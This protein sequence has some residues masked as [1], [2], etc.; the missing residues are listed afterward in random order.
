[1]A[2]T[3][4]RE[5]SS[6]GAL[7]L[8]VVV[9]YVLPV[10]ISLDSWHKNHSLNL[11]DFFNETYIEKM[12]GAWDFKKKY[13]KYDCFKDDW[14]FYHLHHVCTKGGYDGIL[15]GIEGV[16]N[17]WDHR[18]RKDN[19][20]LS[21]DEW[22]K[23]TELN[24]KVHPLRVHRLHENDSIAEIRHLPGSTLYAN[25]YQQP[26]DSMN[27]AH[28]MMKLGTMFE[29]ATCAIH[30][31]DLGSMNNMFMSGGPAATDLPMKQLYLHQC[32]NP[33]LTDWKWGEN[34]LQIIRDQ[35]HEANIF[36]KTNTQFFN[37]DGYQMHNHTKPYYK[38]TCY[39][40]MYLSQRSGI[41]MQKSYNLMEFRKDSA[42]FMGEPGEALTAP[43][44]AADFRT[45]G[46]EYPN[47]AYCK[48]GAEGKPNPR[49]HVFYRSGIK[50][51]RLFLNL[52]AV[53]KLVQEYT[54]LPVVLFTVNA[55]TSIAEQI[56]MFNQFDVM[57]TPHGSHLANG[58]FTVKPGSKA[59]VEIVP[60]AFDRVFYS[61]YN[62]HLEFG[63]YYMSTGHLTPVQEETNRTM[64]HCFFET[65][66]SFSDSHAKCSTTT[67]R[68]PKRPE[69]KFLT[70][71]VLYQPRMCDTMVNIDKL[72]GHLD[73][74][75]KNNLCKAG[76]PAAPVAAAA[77]PPVASAT[78]ATAATAPVVPAADA[79]PDPNDFHRRLSEFLNDK[80]LPS[81]RVV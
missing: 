72:R 76:A 54:T 25:C 81:L 10:A 50:H 66:E 3:M 8:A 30:N 36:Q 13:F 60:Y 77:A 71:D 4:K 23:K 14:Q 38:L 65:E 41:W 61:N 12:K 33:A 24:T 22:N 28:W 18:R 68:Y 59:V 6:L 21:A 80:H 32:P 67:H 2:L 51:R 19:Y 27:P 79:P 53:V 73:D 57:V 74:L 47:P 35:L 16:V 58:I 63:S 39:E 45:N 29:I 46:E 31:T 48:G 20:I 55:T 7:F 9:L 15:I 26:A 44:T 69:Q 5:K 49:I 75:F 37:D 11:F 17:E 78:A 52:D 62:L 34:M 70:C 43:E 42:K 64:H 56:R 1:M 40:D